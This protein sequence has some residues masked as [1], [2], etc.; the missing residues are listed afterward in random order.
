M[1]ET[2]TSREVASGAPADL[3]PADETR[4]AGSATPGEATTT[5]RVATSLL[6]VLETASSEVT[7]CP[8]CDGAGLDRWGTTRRGRQ[9]WRCRGCRRTCT[10]TTG[11][12]LARVHALDKLSEVAADMLACSPRSC[13]ALAAA[14]DLDRMTVWRWRRLIADA[15]AGLVATGE[16][17][18]TATA[19]G[20]TVILRESRKASREWARHRCCPE[21]YPAPD[22]LRWIDYRQQRLP[23]PEPMSRYRTR[24]ALGGG[25]PATTP[26][27]LA[28]RLASCCSTFGTLT[29]GPSTALAGDGA[30]AT[31][32]RGA[33]PDAPR[34]P[35]T[36]ALSTGQFQDFLAPF[37][38]PAS[39][40]LRTYVAWFQ[41]RIAGAA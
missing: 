33:Q 38:G 14:L 11:R 13:R 32:P 31:G 39:R 19:G 25:A 5:A 18:A 21:R 28:G 9:R 3:R 7:T 27:I 4:T 20:E 41:A 10:A 23:L 2:A 26:T 36:T 8:R 34:R 6:A 12:A 17:R 22:R 1:T 16:R 37:A 29:A 24:V 35:S 30:S 40:H 15:W